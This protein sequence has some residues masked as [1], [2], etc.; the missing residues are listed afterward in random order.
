MGSIGCIHI[1]AQNACFDRL[2]P[3]KR[4]LTEASTILT[5]AM[6]SH[7]EPRASIQGHQSIKTRV[8][9]HMPDCDW[10]SVLGAPRSCVSA[11]VGL[12]GVSYPLKRKKPVSPPRTRRGWPFFPFSQPS[13]F[14]DFRSGNGPNRL[15]HVDGMADL[16]L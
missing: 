9:N 2:A 4:I 13:H 1:H 14:E 7:T 15:H 5:T 3:R 8:M 10:P 12:E 6:S 16:T 11:A